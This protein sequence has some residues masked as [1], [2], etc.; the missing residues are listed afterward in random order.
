MRKK[1]SIIF[2]PVFLFFILIVSCSK[3]NNQEPLTNGSTMTAI[4][5]VWRLQNLSGGSKLIFNG[6]NFTIES[7]TVVMKGNFT[8]DGKQ[9]KGVATSRS[10]AGSDW[11]KPNDFVADYVI[12]GN[13]VTFSNYSGNWIL[14]SSWY[15]KQ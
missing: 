2:I 5:G 12:S 11:L 7:G 8:L 15:Q 14:F 3:D 13:K 4:E 6:S 1:I 10:G 9:I